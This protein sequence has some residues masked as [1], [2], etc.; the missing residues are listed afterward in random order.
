MK[1]F[2]KISTLVV[3]ILVLLLLSVLLVLQSP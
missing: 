3:G 1:R 2:L